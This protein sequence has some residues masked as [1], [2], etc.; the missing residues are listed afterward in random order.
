MR[1]VSLVAVCTT[2]FAL[3]A[4][5]DKVPP[6]PDKDPT[7]KV[8][9]VPVDFEEGVDDSI[10]AASDKVDFKILKAPITGRATVTVTF[11]E[12]HGVGGTVAV[13][14]EDGKSS[15]EETPVSNDEH[16][17]KVGFNARAGGLYYLKVA[18]MKGKA[19]YK[20]FFT[21]APPKPT[22]PCE[23]KECGEDQ[24]CKAG[25]CVDVKPAECDP[26]CKSG[27]LCLNGTCEKA[28]A[29]GCKKGEV[30]NTKKNECQKDPCYQKTCAAGERC[31]GGVCKATPVVA[32]TE[33]ECKPACTGTATCNKTTGKCEGGS[34]P[35]PTPSDDCAGPLS[36]NIVQ[37]L[38]QPGKTV[39][40]IN[41]GSKVCVKVGQT[42]KINGV[43][44]SFTISEVYEFRSKAVINVED[45][46][47]GEARSV[48]INR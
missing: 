22:D 36:G 19:K 20:A 42:G 38:P 46:V 2:A 30:C 21:V 33:K 3:A 6:D 8:T 23:G 10:D 34:D 45:K 15:I 40:V 48:V 18:A 26:K 28:C 31:S 16:E 5:G 1:F 27:F 29:G 9:A 35:V 14:E 32:P 44:G 7:L 13:F 47:I 41:R 25:V 12:G 39:L 4:C 11:P 43:A 37:L 24:E 17:Y